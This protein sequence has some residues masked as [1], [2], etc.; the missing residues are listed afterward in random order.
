MNLTSLATAPMK[1]VPRELKQSLLPRSAR[2]PFVK[3]ARRL[4]SAA[5]ALPLAA[6]VPTRAWMALGAVAAIVLALARRNRRRRVEDV[7]IEDVITIDV[8]ATVTEAAQ[9]MREANVGAL[10]I[11]ESGRLCGILTDRDI[12]VRAVA[13]GVNPSTVRVGDCATRDL[14]CARPEWSVDQAL[15]LMSDRQ[16]GRLPVVDKVDRVVGI[17]TLGSLALRSRKPHGALKTA[18]DVSRRSSRIA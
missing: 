6:R 3:L 7:M 11:V 10:P 15:T 18:Q 1:L 4:P 2:R 16:I 9:R 5:R 12:V 8:G 17:V 13:V 14:A